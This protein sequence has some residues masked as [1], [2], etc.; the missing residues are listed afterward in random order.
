MAARRPARSRHL[1]RSRHQDLRLA[2]RHRRAG[3]GARGRPHAPHDRARAARWLSHQ[4]R[5]H[6]Q[7][8]GLQ[9]RLRG[10]GPRRPSV[11]RVVVEP[12]PPPRAGRSRAHVV[13]RPAVDRSGAGLL[14]AVRP[15]G[16]GAER[17]LLEPA[18]PRAHV[19][20]DALR[21]GRAALAVLP[22]QRLRPSA[23]ASAEQAS[24]RPAAHPAERS[25]GPEASVRRVSRRPGRRR[26]PR[27]VDA[28]LRL[29]RP[30]VRA[31][32]RPAHPT[33]LLGG[34]RGLRRGARPRAAE[35]LRPRR[36][37]AVRGVAQPARSRRP[38]HAVALRAGD[39]SQPARFASRVPPARRPRRGRAAAPLAGHRR[40]RPGGPVAGAAAG[41]ASAL[42]RTG[43]C[44][45]RR[46]P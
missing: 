28:H 39:L 2:H 3:G 46:P 10:G 44:S 1:P 21:G 33:A 17:G 12:H 18:R 32:S 7:R 40:R 20:R 24:G 31:P 14:R 45:R 30:A 27:A 5:G 41:R 37:R 8:G 25:A 26:H 29:G 22:L 23:A 34:A 4:H 16:P 15:E 13:H 6:P 42:P 19:D 36:P 9:S 43:R 38:G 11:P 35:S